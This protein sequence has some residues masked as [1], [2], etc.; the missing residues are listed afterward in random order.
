MLKS[1]LLC[2]ITLFCVTTIVGG[3]SFLENS[4]A[5]SL[6]LPL[7]CDYG[8]NCY[9]QKYVDAAEGKASQDY[10]CG[11][12]SNN[13]HKGTDFRLHDYDSLNSGVNVIAAMTG[14]VLE[15]RDYMPDV[16]ADLIDVKSVFNRGYGNMVL[17]QH[18]N[19][20]KTLYAHLKRNSIPLK[21]GQ[22]V[23]AGDVIGMVGQSGLT[24]YPH[25]HFEVL[26]GR[27]RID[28]F[29]GSPLETGCDNENDK[30]LWDTP[31]P[32]KPTHLI[33]IGIFDSPLNRHA[34][35]YKIYQNARLT[36]K[37][38]GIILNAYVAGVQ[39]NDRYRVK[40]F[41]GSQKKPFFDK[42]GR[43]KKDRAFGIISGGKSD[44]GKPWAKG[45]YRA[46]LTYSRETDGKVK[47]L[48]IEKAKATVQ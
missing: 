48:F 4:H 15:V 33:R 24:D 32:Y 5:Q 14:K 11:S 29:T 36:P 16:N 9:I 28:P 21:K 31:L 22:K 38:K 35:E 42:E 17:L 18:D 12:L 20:Y 8:K 47:V 7:E 25:L 40:L 45:T 27:N 39:K 3:V 10:R 2:R 23:Q 43:Y 46:E 19:D 6:Q 26:K 34:M 13:D 1:P 37:S 30:S 44:I 41:Y